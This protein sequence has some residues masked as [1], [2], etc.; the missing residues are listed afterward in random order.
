MCVTVMKATKA[1]VLNVLT[2]TTACTDHAP[3]KLAAETLKVLVMSA[4]VP[5]KVSNS[6][7]SLQQLFDTFKKGFTWTGNSSTVN[8]CKDVDE[9]A[10]RSPCGQNSVCGNNIGSFTCQ[11]GFEA[12]SLELLC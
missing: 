3:W 11:L 5:S 6:I 10:T 4:F 8:E 7:S 2:L 1:M 12:S 9:C